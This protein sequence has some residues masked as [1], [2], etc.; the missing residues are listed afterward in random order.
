MNQKQCKR[1][2]KLMPIHDEASKKIYRRLKKVFQHELSA[3]ERE[4]F[5]S[6]IQNLVETVN[7][8]KI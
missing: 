3:N 5:F 2:R 4:E 1:L 6:K 7:T 8:N